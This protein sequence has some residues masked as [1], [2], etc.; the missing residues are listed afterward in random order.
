M[1]ANDGRFFGVRITRT[2]QI[3]LV[4]ALTALT[5]LALARMV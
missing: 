3:G 5:L 2:Q 1:P 4:L